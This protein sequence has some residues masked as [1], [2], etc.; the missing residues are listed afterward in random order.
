M[1]VTPICPHL[2][3]IRPIVVPGESAIMV[4]VTGVPNEIFLT[5]DGQEAV[6]MH[7][8]DEV[9]C[10]RSE[11]QRAAAAAEA[12]RA[13]QCAAVEAEVGRAAS[14]CAR[15]GVGLVYSGKKIPAE[16]GGGADDS[17]KQGADD[18]KAGYVLASEVEA[19]DGGSGAEAASGVLRGRCADAVNLPMPVV[20]EVARS[21]GRRELSAGD[22]AGDLGYLALSSARRRA[23]RPCLSA[24]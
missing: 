9:R 24:S 7:V 5:V 11:Y 13:V 3:T 8:G 14:L 18:P 17:A 1:V 20:H 15:C 10:C 21:D 19:A 12:E 22:V 6:P 16:R 2:L 23:A 4:R